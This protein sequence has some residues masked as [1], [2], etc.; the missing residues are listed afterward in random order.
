MK[1]GNA[2]YIA[3]GEIPETIPVFPLTGALLL[4]GGQLPLN[5]FEPRYLEMIDDAVRGDKMIGMIQPD[6]TKGTD[7]NGVSTLSEV[8]CIGRISAFQETG[9]GRYHISLSGVCRFRVV[10]ELSVNT[11]YRQCKVTIFESDLMEANDSEAVDREAVLVAFKNYLDANNMDADWETVERAETETLVTALCMMSP[12]EAAEKQALL[13][14]PTLKER[15][16]TLIAI[17]EMHLAKSGDDTYGNL[18]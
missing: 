14:A 8:G 15:A 9:D 7:S 2:S 10:E 11:G 17:S 5:I 1:A 18:Q 12:Y 13:E 6:L 16:E 4:P 3:A